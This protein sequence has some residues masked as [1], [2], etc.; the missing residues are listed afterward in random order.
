VSTER[1]FLVTGATGAIGS[2]VVPLLLA[3]PETRVYMLLRAPSEQ[4]LGARVTGLVDFWGDWI[5]P[6]ELKNRLAAVTGDVCRPKLGMSERDHDTLAGVV[7]N[8]VHSAGDVKLNQSIEQA[9]VSAVVAAA[10]VAQF[11]RSCARSRPIPKIEHLS[12]VGV[13][14]R[15]PGLIPEEP[16]DGT[17][18]YHNAYEQAK[19]EAEAFLRRE[20]NDGLPVTLHRP[21]MVVGDSR[22]GRIIRFQVFYHLIRF[23]AG[24]RTRG[25]LPRFGDVRL[26]LI[27][28]DYVAK[29]VVASSRRA[30]SAGRIFHLCSGTNGAIPLAQ[31]GETLRHFLSAQGEAV[32]APRYVS[33]RAMRGIVRGTTY[34]TAGRTRRALQSLPYFLDYLEEAQRF[35]NEAA[36]QFFQADHILPPTPEQFL[37]PVLR[38]WYVRSS[39]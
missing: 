3:E 36:K 16:L 19:A 26:D 4:A 35:A 20:M 11:A 32:Q 25:W 21:S 6:N 37:M 24:S 10:E 27:P 33:R 13:A 38:Y 29:A 17:F 34:L 7:T 18:G 23:I 28:S 9:R 22:D 8:I 1:V 31:L 5:D 15:R 39:T 30:D 14:G 2:A 12:T